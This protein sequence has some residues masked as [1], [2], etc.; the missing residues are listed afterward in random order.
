MTGLGPFDIPGH[1]LAESSAVD[2]KIRVKGL[3]LAMACLATLSIELQAIQI[4]FSTARAQR[5]GLILAVMLGAAT[6]AYKS[7][8]SRSVV[9]TGAG[10]GSFFTCLLFLSFATRAA[11]SS[12]SGADVVSWMV[13]AVCL[14]LLW[15][16]VIL[17]GYRKR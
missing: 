12:V 8:G 15:S 4:S 11:W 7:V 16:A 2:Q 13:V 14:G 5:I 9:V 3:I 6:V 1:T 10:L 17:L